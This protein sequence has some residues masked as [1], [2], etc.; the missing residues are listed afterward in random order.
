MDSRV[1][2]AKKWRDRGGLFS[3]GLKGMAFLA[4]LILAS[5]GMAAAGYPFVP[6]DFDI[7]SILE[8]KD[9]R[10]RMLSVHDLVKDFDAVISSS[11]K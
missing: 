10:L 11:E 4:S 7:P 9:Y 3:G 2:M 1:V 6:S 5:P 8:T